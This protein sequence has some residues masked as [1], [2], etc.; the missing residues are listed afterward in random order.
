MVGG[1]SLHAQVV[2][3][4]TPYN[5]RDGLLQ[6]QVMTLLQDNNGYLWLGTHRG[7]FK[8]DGQQF[9]HLEPDTTENSVG[10]FLTDILE[11][12]DGR[13][14]FA[15]SSG[16]SMLDGG[17]V[18]KYTQKNGLKDVDIR[19][20]SMDGQG[21]LWVGSRNGNLFYIEG[22][23]L[24][25]PEITLPPS[26]KETS[27][28]TLLLDKEG[29]LWIGTQSGLFYL[30]L[31]QASL[32]ISPVA[33]PGPEAYPEVNALEMIGDSSIWVGVKDGIFHQRAGQFARLLTLDRAVYCMAESPDGQV[34]LGTER[35][36]YRLFE[37]QPFPLT[38][39]NRLLDFELRAAIVDLEGNIWFGTDGGG[40]RKITKGA[41]Q[42]YDVATGLNS[43]LAK[44]FL[45]DQEG[46][47]WLSTRNRGINLLADDRVVQ[48]FTTRNSG[49]GG[50]QI[51][52]SFEDSEGRFWFASFNGTLSSY[53]NGRFEV[54]DRRDGLNCTQVYCITEIR[55]NLYWVGTDQG[56]FQMRNKRFRPLYNKENGLPDEKVY[57]LYPD[58][59]GT[60]W[61]GTAAGLAW[62][63]NGRLEAR[64]M[65]N[66]INSNV[67]SILED[68]RQQLW[69]GSSAGLAAHVGEQWTWVRTKGGKGANTTVSLVMEKKQY[70]WVG[71]EDG[72]FRLNLDDF[73][74]SQA[75]Q[76]FE[77]YSTDDGLPSLECNANAGFQDSRGNI[78]IGTSE[79]AIRRAPGTER[80][81]KSQRPLVYITDVS[82]ASSEELDG[83]WKKLGFRVDEDG[84]P[85][86]LELPYT[87]NR[88]DFQFIGISLKS[89]EKV[90]YRF[91]LEGVDNDWQRPS[92]TLRVPYPNLSPGNYTFKVTSKL[93]G[94]PWEQETYYD[95]FSFTILPPIWQ[96][97][98]FILLAMAVVAGVLYL[99][100]RTYN[101][102]RMQLMEERRIR[103]KA[104]KLQLEH[105]ALYAMMN[106]HFTFNAL[107]SIQYFIHQQDRISAN[108]F[109]S[110]FAKLVRKNL[111]S[112]K[113]DFITLGEEVE[114]LKLY[115]SLER[116]R[117]PEKFD[118]TVEVDPSI[119]LHETQI[120]PMLL[121]PFVENSIK[122]G[123]MSLDADGLISVHIEREDEDYLKVH[124][125]DNGIG[126]E[127][128][129][130]RKANRPTDHVSK[131]MQITLDRLALFA[132]MTQKEYSLNIQEIKEGVEVQGTEVEIIL[133]IKEEF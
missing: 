25:Y 40:A 35:G 131:G 62:V 60:T 90:E 70:L 67:I 58:R 54:F 33:L 47:I 91:K 68:N 44:S 98:W 1:L 96:R 46:V 61:I 74:P 51:C 71:T 106:P 4:V 14:W 84:L 75:K 100:Y 77:I 39:N 38:Q 26:W 7:V 97:S 52:T 110:S 112:T 86:N 37:G 34:W 72:A 63:Q 73:D 59:K 41:F 87:D 29:K 105:Q 109:L 108:K 22:D 103:D 111:E 21:R 81:S 93:Q 27:I 9:F 120:P 95:E 12:N 117:F 107:Q 56:I 43:N 2:Y 53:E 94:E 89:P 78:W 132:R 23:S 16:L 45:E 31:N 18:R 102:R 32:T 55:K 17:E 115:L 121:Q 20:L 69:V 24:T 30:D 28:E 3:N 88:I 42:T 116:M 128:S 36:A 11:G 50:D 48:T 101:Q 127:E 76:N 92:G 83:S 130:K 57:A 126:I 6:S 10:S 82:S 119:E 133:P 114:R 124:I 104:E 79:G 129:K 19:S 80:V 85:I 49:L 64:P 125:R 99:V 118:Y 5:N 123:I 66:I 65:D 122:H 8:Y 15:S 13:M 113:T